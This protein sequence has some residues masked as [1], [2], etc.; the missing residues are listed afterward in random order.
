MLD[1]CLVRVLLFYG[2]SSSLGLF[3]EKKRKKAAHPHNLVCV[4]ES[5]TMC[6]KRDRVVHLSCPHALNLIRA[7]R[8]NGAVYVV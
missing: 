6:Y 7:H 2:V 1:A 3:Y 8:E 5:D 4:V